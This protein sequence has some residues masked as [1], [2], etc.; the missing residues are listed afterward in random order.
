MNDDFFPTSDSLCVNQAHLDDSGQPD[1]D[2]VS[3]DDDYEPSE[4][5]QSDLDDDLS[6][7]DEAECSS[8]NTDL[9]KSWK[10]SSRLSTIDVGPNSFEYRGYKYT[11]D[12]SNGKYSC[13]LCGSTC[14]RKY[15]LYDHIRNVHIGR[16]GKLKILDHCGAICFGI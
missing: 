9:K 10:N 2:Q 5:H 13:A 14:G 3:G 11:L 1:E 4:V 16:G 6:S 15:H 8:G 7:P 12:P